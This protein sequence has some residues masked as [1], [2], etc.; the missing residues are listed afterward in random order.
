MDATQNATPKPDL[1]TVAKI[2]VESG[3][4]PVKKNQLVSLLHWLHP[5]LS[6]EEIASAFSRVE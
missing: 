6:T 5:E 2:S 3:D 4:R 1:S